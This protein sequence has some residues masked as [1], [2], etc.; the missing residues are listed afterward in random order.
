MTNLTIDNETGEILNKES[1]TG[2]NSTNQIPAPTE[3]QDQVNAAINEVP[4]K[5]KKKFVEEMVYLTHEIDAINESLKDLK[6]QAKEMGYNPVWLLTV[7]KAIAAG[8]GQELEEK[9]KGMLEVLD[10]VVNE[11]LRS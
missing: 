9:S 10:E 7:A 4:S 5:S 1:D 11:I 6:G 3:L 8:K 2:M